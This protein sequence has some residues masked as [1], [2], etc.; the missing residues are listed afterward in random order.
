M[1]GG[2]SGFDHNLFFAIVRY[3]FENFVDFDV[4]RFKLFFDFIMH[5]ILYYPLDCLFVLIIEHAFYL[6]IIDLWMQTG[7]SGFVAVLAVM[8]PEGATRDCGGGDP[9]LFGNI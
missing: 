6:T 4:M 8:K 9:H 7:E 1:M 2:N 3:Y 5:Y